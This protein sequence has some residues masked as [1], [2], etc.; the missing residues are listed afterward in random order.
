MDMASDEVL[1]MEVFRRIR[2]AKY[3]SRNI[4][5]LGPPGSGKSSNS[6]F[7]EHEFCYCHFRL[8][9]AIGELIRT[10]SKYRE[11]FISAKKEGKGLSEEF[12]NEA[13]R[14][15]V[16]D[17][18]CDKGV[19]FDA[20]PQTPQ[21]A[22]KLLEILKEKGPERKIDMVI[23][24]M[25]PETEIFDRIKGRLVHQNSGRVYHEKF[26]PPNEENQD[27]LTKEPL[28]KKKGDEDL[29]NTKKRLGLYKKN[30][31][32]MIEKFRR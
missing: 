20:Y 17:A 7:I 11:E 15:K 26:F 6:F 21:Q 5:L 22:D 10:N 18:S 13:I 2:C 27:N 14:E 19:V 8:S 9:R 28:Y 23:Q 32:S 1:R 30:S 12:I 25:L 3:P 4:V 31:E 24:M 16:L 29:E